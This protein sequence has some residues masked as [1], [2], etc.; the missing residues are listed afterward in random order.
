METLNRPKEQIDATPNWSSSEMLYPGLWVYR[1]VLK[2]NLN[3]INR[4]NDLIEKN[5]QIN[6]QEAQVGYQNTIKNYRDCK[7]IKFGYRENPKSDEE[8]QYADIWMDMYKTKYPAA[9]DYC[10]KYSIQMDYWELMNF[11]KYEPNQHF[12]EH[13][14]HGFSYSA[15]VSLVGYP[16]DDY[17]GGD[18]FFPKLGINIKAK[19]GDLYIFPSTYLFSHV[20]KPVISGTKYSVVT[21]LDYNDHAHN[22]DFY[23]MR[24]QRIDNA[25]NKSL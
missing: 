5:P 23:R 17:E 25:S 9:Q 3:L 12:Q 2:N 19:A 13:A 16:N 14:D 18:L 15:T 4:V 20:A 21:M 1:D 24:K 7:D 10:N 6:W 11:I 22:E 8:K